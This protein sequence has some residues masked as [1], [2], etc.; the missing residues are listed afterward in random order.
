MLS[1][2]Y[3]TIKKQE[4]YSCLF[5]RIW[6]LELYIWLKT[7]NNF[8]MKIRSTPGKRKTLPDY[9]KKNHNRKWIYIHKRSAKNNPYSLY[10]LKIITIIIAVVKPQCC[11]LTFLQ[12]ETWSKESFWG[13]GSSLK[14]S[15]SFLH[16]WSCLQ[17]SIAACL[18]IFL[19]LVLFFLLIF[20]FFVLFC[21]LTEGR[22]FLWL[23]RLK[24]CWWRLVTSFGNL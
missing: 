8:Q 10:N 3:L 6:R 20:V 1:N 2:A 18:V 23:G 24:F 15:S 22:N 13:S 21:G 12:K 7:K 5:L 17:W 14:R 4:W 19:C 16:W 11:V 9:E